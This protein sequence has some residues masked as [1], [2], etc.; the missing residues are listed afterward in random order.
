M[1]VGAAARGRQRQQMSDLLFQADDFMPCRIQARYAKT[2]IYTSY[3][4]YNPKPQEARL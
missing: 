2:V 3:S 4:T 1:Y